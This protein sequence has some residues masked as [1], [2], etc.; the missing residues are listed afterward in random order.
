MSLLRAFI[1]GW[2]ECVASIVIDLGGTPW[3][4]VAVSTRKHWGMARFLWRV[5]RW[6]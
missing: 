1:C 5:R 2:L 3:H 4:A 6:A